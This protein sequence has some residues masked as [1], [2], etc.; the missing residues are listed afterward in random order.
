[1]GDKNTN[2]VLPNNVNRICGGTE[3]QGDTTTQHDIRIDG[4]YEGNVKCAGKLIIGETGV[5]KGSI[6]C[7]QLDVWG[8]LSGTVEVLDVVSFK[9]GAIFD[10]ELSTSKLM[11]DLGVV[12]NGSCTMKREEKQVKAQA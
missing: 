4:K 5:F 9:L 7:K 8:H 6:Q 1:M 11:M 12:F 2:K 3:I 10:G